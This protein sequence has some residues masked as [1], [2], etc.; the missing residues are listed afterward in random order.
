MR[1]LWALVA[2]LVLVP[3]ASAQAAPPTCTSSFPPAEDDGRP[4]G[5]SIGCQGTLDVPLKFE[6]V[7]GPSHGTLT[8]VEDFT[9][10]TGNAS[11]LPRY[12]PNAGH[13][14]PDSF[15]VRAT[16]GGE[17]VTHA[18]AVNVVAAVDDP[19][20]CLL[21]WTNV[22]NV[23]GRVQLEAGETWHGNIQCGD[24]EG[25]TLDIAVYQ[26]PNHGVLT[27]LGPLGI[28]QGLR[29]SYTPSA[30]YRGPDTF[31]FQAS[32][33]THTVL[34]TP[35]ITVIEPTDDAPTC[36]PSL[37]LGASRYE[38]AHATPRELTWACGDP[39]GKPLTYSVAKAPA[40]G[41]VA[42][43]QPDQFGVRATYTPVAGH[44]GEDEF[45]VRAQ[46]GP[47][48]LEHTFKV[49]V[50][51]APVTPVTP[52]VETPRIDPPAP[53]NT[54]TAKPGVV[55]IGSPVKAVSSLDQRIAKACGK[56]KG[57]RK[58]TC[59]KRERALAKCNAM[60]SRT[61]KQKSAKRRCTA[62]AKLIGVKKPPTKR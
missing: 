33:G 49:S 14:G 34:S 10:P 55:V 47:H 48:V 23:P 41:T 46:D 60:K 25:D 16:A 32:D 9:F 40:H 4:T 44:T 42:L 51:A 58:A 26:Q 39:E 27:I 22:P 8:G 57:T 38:V 56:L 30:S 2:L 29:F 1:V 61:S 7:S 31:T 59:A 28:S 35:L 36:T 6:L 50:L 18:V 12:T 52:V 11:V 15:T 45:T 54:N 21:N 62:K 24:D 3:A 13:R 37:L 5:G 20:A 43:T 19:P 17:S 53:T